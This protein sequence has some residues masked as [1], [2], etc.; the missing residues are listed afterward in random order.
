MAH[1]AET[2]NPPLEQFRPYL[3]LLARSQLA[4]RLRGKLDPSDLVQ[5]TLL[6]AHA[7]REQF[8]GRT[9][10]ECAAY[11][12]GILTHNLADVLRHYGAAGRDVAAERTLS[13]GDGS[14]GEWDGWLAAPGST[15]SQHAQRDEELLGLARALAQLPEEQRVAVELKHLQ[16]YSVEEI[17]REL[18][19]STAAVGG[20]LRRGLHRL[21]SW[22]NDE[23]VS[24][25]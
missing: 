21:R 9:E 6:K 4:P 22:M 8:R 16:G 3:R 5:Q 1:G 24:G 15:P 19:H 11:L 2:L 20:L 23:G 17:S 10:A 7:R 25:P 18:G 12:C 13:A 14:S